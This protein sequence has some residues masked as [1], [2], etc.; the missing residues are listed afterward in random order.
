M[1]LPA[2][3]GRLSVEEASVVLPDRQN[4]MLL[5]VS[6]DLQ[7][8]S[9]LG[10]I[11]PSGAGKTTLARALVGLQPLSRG[12]V[13][14]DDAALTDQIRMICVSALERYADRAAGAAGVPHP[15]RRV[16]AGLALQMVRQSMVSGGVAS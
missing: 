8:G 2:P 7:P 1:A 11:G 6:F 12:H 10:I 14:I 13:R 9:S 4:P 15:D 5:G 16:D 3:E